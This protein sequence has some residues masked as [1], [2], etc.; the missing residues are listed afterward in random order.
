M[1]EL[2]AGIGRAVIT[3][4]PGMALM[5][6]IHREYG[7]AAVHDDLY[8]TALV[9]SDGRL[10]LA[11]VC[12][13]LLMLHPTTVARIRARTAALTGIPAGQLMLCCSHTHSGPVTYV[14]D[15]AAWP[16]RRAYL[17]G[18]V[19]LAAAA[20]A[21]G[22]AHMQP[23]AWGM[24]Q[25]QVQIGVNRRQRT[26]AGATVIGEDPAGPV[27]PTLSVF[28][29]DR[30][31]PDGHN[32]RP[33]ALLV[34]Y[35]CHAVCLGHDSYLVSADWPGEMRRL[36]EA[37]TGARVGFVQGAC[38][39]VNPLG[40]PRSD[41]ESLERLGRQVGEQV[42]AVYAGISL[43]R[44]I[45]LAAAGEV[46]RL[47]LLLRHHCDISDVPGAEGGSRGLAHTAGPLLDDRFPWAAQ[48]VEVDGARYALAE[49]QVLRLGHTVLAGVAAEPFV[50]IGLQVKAGSPAAFTCFAGYTNGS[51][52]YIPVPAA[53]AQGGY[54]VDESYVYYRLP[55]PLAPSAAG[56][57]RD[58]T[59]SLIAALEE[60]CH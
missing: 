60:S 16:L 8:A 11:L 47:P 46:L 51:I 40:G 7:A 39:D 42:C 36:V 9:L 29:V 52:G 38:A 23:A 19:E 33:L 5:G 24:G 21:E 37:Q 25:G 49:L 55:G 54:E 32:A 17:D 50:E 15:D 59:L 56:E 3:P 18:L 14:T 44:D 10:Q 12:C 27:D 48:V 22:A 31:D 28:R 45:H 4:P 57:V 43:Q 53:Y 2:S 20:V 34:H 13:D 30:T 26:A 6:Y 35:A 41:F 58:E 1:G